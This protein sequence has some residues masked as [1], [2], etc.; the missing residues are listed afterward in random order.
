MKRLNMQHQQ[1]LFAFES[2]TDKE[3]LLLLKEIRKDNNLKRFSI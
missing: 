2:K 1:M 3:Q